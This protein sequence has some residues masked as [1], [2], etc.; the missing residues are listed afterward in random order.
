MRYNNVD[1][2]FANDFYVVNWLGGGF[3]DDIST[4][5]YA[6]ADG[7]H[8]N[9]HHS[10]DRQ[11]IIT[12][13]AFNER[14]KQAIYR[15]FM[16][17]RTGVLTYLPD[18]DDSRAV[19][20][21]CEVKSKQPAQSEFPMNILVTLTCPYPH[22][23]SATQNTALISGE[24]NKWTFPWLFPSEKT[25]IFSETKGGN[26]VIFDYG[27]TIATGFKTVINTTQELKYVKI[28]NFYTGEYLLVEHDFPGNSE[29]I[30]S[31]EIGAK[32]VKWR[33]VNNDEYT[34]VTND[35]VWGSTY[36]QLSSGQN[37]VLLETTNGTAG[38]EAY[39][40][41]TAKQGGT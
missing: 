8:V 21:D 27:G 26:S 36:F 22:W 4:T 17:R 35:V 6:T 23:R 37:R 41:Y 20:I 18:N 30:I 32:Y 1:L 19:Q 9:G 33:L 31:T 16:E 13:R 10:S 39:V 34:D 15:M 38:I 7:S 11:I 40:S 14:Q 25:F 24:V 28:T 12:M 2:S 29:I 5:S 3:E